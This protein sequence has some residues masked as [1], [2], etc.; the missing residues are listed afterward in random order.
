M[1][2][3]GDRDT[4]ATGLLSDGAGS[5]R[6]LSFF[7]GTRPQPCPYL[8]GHIE[9][10]VVTDLA[11]SHAQAIHDEL[12]LAGFRRSHNLI[13]KPACVGCQ[14]CVPVRIPVDRFAPSRSQR[15]ILRANHDI[16]VT[17]APPRATLEHYALFDCYQ[18]ARHAGGGMASMSYTDFR[19]MIEETPVD[20]RLVE[21]RTASGELVG[22]SLTDWLADGYSGVYK[23]FD[24]E[25]TGRSLGTFLVLWHVQQARLEG[26]PHVYLGY[27][28][29][30]C[31][32]MSYKTR[33]RPIEALG[34]GG[35]IDLVNEE[36]SFS[37]AAGRSSP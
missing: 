1:T 7:F 23:F 36:E 12:S 15:R 29:G 16:D 11:G 8:D 6:P 35:W 17:I 32:K 14:A 28:I 18:Q 34:P 3:H 2:R 25:L 13:Y 19:A 9:S 37:T 31:D 20:T 33:F 5:S 30:A 26:L 27:W 24:P 22:V 21:A 4:E 10:K